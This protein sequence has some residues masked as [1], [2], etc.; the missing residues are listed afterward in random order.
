MNDK[1]CRIKTALVLLIFFSGLLITTIQAQDIRVPVCN[2]NLQDIPG[3]SSA[4]LDQI[5]KLNAVTLGNAGEAEDWNSYL[6]QFRV[7]VNYFDSACTK[8][9]LIKIV[10]RNDCPLI[11]CYAFQALVTPENAQISQKEIH[12][13]LLLFTNDTSSCVYLDR[14]CGRSRIDM[15]D[16]LLSLVSLKTV[17]FYL[18]GVRPLENSP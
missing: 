6:G 17:N 8:P 18:A 2:I 11:T 12:H 1:S 5:I 9:E 4:K 16:Y 13:L 14:G 10:S 15:F 7:I 3:L